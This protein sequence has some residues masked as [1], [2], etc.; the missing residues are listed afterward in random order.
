MEGGR[1]GGREEGGREGGGREGEREGGGREGKGGI[2]LGGLRTIRHCL[3][4]KQA[5]TSAAHTNTPDTVRA[6]GWCTHRRILSTPPGTVPFVAREVLFEPATSSAIEFRR[7]NNI[8]IERITSS[9]ISDEVGVATH[10]IS[11]MEGCLAALFCLLVFFPYAHT[12]ELLDFKQ[13]S[14]VYLPKADQQE[15]DSVY[16]VWNAN[17]EFVRKHNQRNS[18]FSL[19]VNKFAHLVSNISIFLLHYSLC[20]LSLS[21][22]H[23]HSL[24]HSFTY[25]HLINYPSFLLL[26]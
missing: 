10:V 15:L 21:L 19:S 26:G 8:P 24:T 4:W 1:K 2:S 22:S 9:S 17:A 14:S 11:I 18:Q 5:I 6:A 25:R 16:P 3:T 12:S 23:T 13:W 20:A 7:E